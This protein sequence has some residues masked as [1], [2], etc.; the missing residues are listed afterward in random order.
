MHSL[1]DLVLKICHG[2]YGFKNP[3]QISEE[4]KDLIANLLRIEPGKRFTVEQALNHS[5]FTAEKEKR[6]V[7]SMIDLDLKKLTK[8]HSDRKGTLS[9]LFGEKNFQKGFM[10]MMKV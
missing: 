10:P 3:E 6:P 9:I 2:E 5:W 1:N 8:R 4:A 7:L